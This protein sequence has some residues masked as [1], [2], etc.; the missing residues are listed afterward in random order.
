MFPGSVST[1]R[2]TNAYLWCALCARV[3]MC[4]RKCILSMCHGEASRCHK[5]LNTFVLS[6]LYHVMHC[7]WMLIASCS[8]CSCSVFFAI[9]IGSVTAIASCYLDSLTLFLINSWTV[10]MGI[11]IIQI[12]SYHQSASALAY[13]LVDL[14]LI[15]HKVHSCYKHYS[16]RKCVNF[17]L[18]GTSLFFLLAPFC[19]VSNFLH[20][21]VLLLPTSHFKAIS[22][23]MLM[24]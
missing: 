11:L 10:A 1:S 20:P 12:I 8:P 2:G 17:F 18:S 16:S 13:I 5:L 4:V 3:C 6:T 22:A 21:S 24:D 23:L 19:V 9:G 15:S 14:I 7:L